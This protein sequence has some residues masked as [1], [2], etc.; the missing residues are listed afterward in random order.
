MVLQREEDCMGTVRA[1]VSGYSNACDAFHQTATS[2]DATGPFMAMQ[3]A[4]KMSHLSPAD[5]HYINAHGTGTPNNDLTESV[6]INRL[7]NENAPYISSTKA[8][9]GHTTSASGAIELVICLLAMEHNFIPANLGCT[10]PL[11]M[12]TKVEGA[13]SMFNVQCS[14]IPARVDNVMCNA[15]GFGG[16][17]S[18]LIISRNSCG[19]DFSSDSSIDVMVVAENVID[20][21]EQLKDSKD[22]IPPM[23]ARR[24]GKL[25]KAATMTALKTLKDAGIARPD[26]IITATALGMADNSERFL[27]AMVENDET[28]LPPTLFMQSTH[29]TIGSSLAIRLGCHGYNITYTQGKDSLEWAKR[30][31]VRLIKTGK[32]DSVLVGL[33]DESTPLLNDLRLRAKKQVLPMIYSKSILYM[34]K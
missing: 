4:L 6:A 7:F 33:H 28:L 34:K 3:Q 22:I 1:Y 16:N 15:F 17:D 11:Q 24:M 18:S 26:A 10:K 13:S 27:N 21:I 5:I 25:L 14:I 32:A 20:N 31:A 2:A 12:M 19:N 30:D 29:N 9:T 23:E 8:Y